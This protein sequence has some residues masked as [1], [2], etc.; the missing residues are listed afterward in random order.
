MYV[1]YPGRDAVGGYMPCIKPGFGIPKVL[2]FVGIC[3]TPWLTGKP[4]GMNEEF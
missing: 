3:A 2:A 1:G 4:Y